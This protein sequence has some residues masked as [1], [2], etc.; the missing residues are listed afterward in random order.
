MLEQN[1]RPSFASGIVA[2]VGNLGD[3][4]P[5]SIMLIIM[6]DQLSLS[7]GKLIYGRSFPGYY[8]AP[9]TSS[10]VILSPY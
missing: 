4:D 6:A 8:S 5:P 9:C 10:Y 7:V 2:S 3:F 1:I